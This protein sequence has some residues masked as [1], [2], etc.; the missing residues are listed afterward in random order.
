[1]GLEVHQILHIDPINFH[2]LV[3]PVAISWDEASNFVVVVALCQ[4]FN[5]LFHDILKILFY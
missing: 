5:K 3:I 4:S 1:M 2:S